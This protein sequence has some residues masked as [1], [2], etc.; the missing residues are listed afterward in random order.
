MMR[1]GI[2]K[3]K[4]L[5]IKAR[6]KA[7]GIAEELLYHIRTIS[8]FANFDYEIKRFNQAFETKGSTRILNSGMVQ[9]IINLGIYFGFSMTCIYARKLVESD[10]DYLTVHHLFTAGDVVKVLVAV[11]K[12]IISMVELPPNIIA[13]QEACASSSDYFILRDR[14][15]E[16]YASKNNLAPNRDTIKGKIE[17]RNIKFAYPDDKGQK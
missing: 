11:R 14:V 1:Y 15:P 16:I 7:G 13:I 5:S 8:S 12:S 4:I 6:E 2:E 9:G 17:F 3:E 10:Y